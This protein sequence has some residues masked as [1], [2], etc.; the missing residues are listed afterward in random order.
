V[1]EDV[2]RAVGRC[3]ETEAFLIAEPLN[4]SCSHVCY[5]Y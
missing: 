5:L 3:D 4:C 2:F 1:N